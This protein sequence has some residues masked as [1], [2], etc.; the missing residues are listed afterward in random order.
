[1]SILQKVAHFVKLAFFFVVFLFVFFKIVSTFVPVFFN[2]YFILTLKFTKTTMNKKLLHSLIYLTFLLG[3]TSS[4]LSAQVTIGDGI[5]P[6]EFSILELVSN[7]KG[8]LR[9][10][11]L[12]TVERDAI[13]S[14]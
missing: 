12:T 1:M 13:T 5:A 3:I 6:Q 9:M 4:Q 14:F 10:P 2:K 7:S 11:R 8:G